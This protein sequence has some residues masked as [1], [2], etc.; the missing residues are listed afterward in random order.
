M[1]IPNEVFIPIVVLISVAIG[2]FLSWIVKKIKEKSPKTIEVLDFVLEI[3]EN[4]I[5]A[6]PDLIEKSWAIFYKKIKSWIETNI[7]I[8]LTEEQWKI[9]DEKLLEI[10]NKLKEELKTES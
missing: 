1:Q 10:Y 8:D 9:I 4:F 6:N 7:K 5:Y 3:I 2:Y